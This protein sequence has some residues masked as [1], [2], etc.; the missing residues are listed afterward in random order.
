MEQNNETY[1]VT[2][3]DEFLNESCYY[4][5]EEFEKV[6]DVL[7]EVDEDKYVCKECAEMYGIETIDA[8]GG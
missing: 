2:V 7:V 8:I 3:E 6:E 4:C 1:I 5:Q